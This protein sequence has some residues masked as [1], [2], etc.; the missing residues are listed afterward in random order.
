M[1]F[2]CSFAVSAAIAATAALNPAAAQVVAPLANTTQTVSQQLDW[3]QTTFSPGPPPAGT[4]AWRGL[5]W[6]SMSGGL[7]DRFTL[8]GAGAVQTPGGHALILGHFGP[9]DPVAQLTGGIAR[10]WPSAVRLKTGAFGFDVSPQVGFGAS[11]GADSQSAGA[12]V[13]FGKGLGLSDAEAG[14][15]SKWYLFASTNQENVGL[16]FMRNEEAWRR[17]GLAPDPGAVIGDTRAG[18]AWRD[19]PFEASVGYLYREIHPHDLDV[20]DVST[21][22]ESLVAFRLTLH[23]GAKQ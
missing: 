13:R 15:R 12:L 21:N 8:T 7:I 18:V 6:P 16:G 22:K 5:V 11:G 17:Q 2:V 10:D 23:P 3:S 14:A 1:R 20:L 4:S 19:G 9:D